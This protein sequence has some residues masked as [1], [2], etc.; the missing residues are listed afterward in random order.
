M[1][2]L[3]QIINHST[4]IIQKIV[5]IEELSELIKELTKDLRGQ[6]SN[7]IEEL[8]DVLVMIEQLKIIYKLDNDEIEGM[9]NDKIER[10]LKRLG[11]I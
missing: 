6:K 8:C 7:V 10:T 3:Q 5:A 2:K 1:N 9:M 11:A 4:P